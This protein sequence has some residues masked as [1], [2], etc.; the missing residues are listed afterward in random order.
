MA[1]GSQITKKIK[2]DPEVKS[3]FKVPSISRGDALKKIW[4]Y[5]RKN[6]LG[7]IKVGGKSGLTLDDELQF[8]FNTTKKKIKNTEIM[9]LMKNIFDE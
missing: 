5:I 2:L 3:F 8:I 7:G 1:R 4:A 9:S 6:E